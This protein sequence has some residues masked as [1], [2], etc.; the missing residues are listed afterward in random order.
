MTFTWAEGDQSL[1]DYLAIVAD[2]FA[3]EVREAARD[4][5]VMIGEWCLD[6]AAK[7]PST[8]PDDARRAYFRKIADAQLSAW[9]PAV[10]WT[11][12]SYK[13]QTED[14]QHDPWDMGRAIEL[15]WL[16]GEGALGA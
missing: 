6:T 9:A 3:V 1:E 13:L 10:A 5:E 7:E 11:Y 2:R 4:V 16:P 12:W 15:G 14:R 8:L